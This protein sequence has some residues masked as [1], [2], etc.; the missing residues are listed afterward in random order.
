M[1]N[2]RINGQKLNFK[3]T[4]TESEINVEL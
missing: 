3:H 4:H 1:H 2:K